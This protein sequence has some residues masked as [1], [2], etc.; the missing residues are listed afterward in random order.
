MLAPGFPQP[1]ARAGSAA[2]RVRAAATPSISPDST[3][4]PVLPSS[5][6][7]GT[8]PTARGDGRQ[9][10]AEALGYRLRNAFG[11]RVSRAQSAAAKRSRR[12]HGGREMNAPGDPQRRG[13]RLHV[14]A[15][16]SFSGEQQDGLR[17]R[18]DELGKCAQRDFVALHRADHAD[19]QDDES[20]VVKAK[21]RTDGLARTFGDEAFGNRCRWG[22]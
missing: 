3:R 15:H 12:R 7:S 18:F 19:H 5:M 1:R 6:S 21:R 10:A 16:R 17:R 2:M 11:A 22:C 13:Q 9:A 14:A 4:R 20:R 8:P